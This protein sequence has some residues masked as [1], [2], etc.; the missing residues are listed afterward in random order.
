VAPKLSHSN[1]GDSWIGNV[2]SLKRVDNH[3]VFEGALA[4]ARYSASVV[5]CATTL[6]FLDVYEMGLI[7]KK[8]MYVDVDVRS[9]TFPTQ[10]T[11]E[12]VFKTEGPAL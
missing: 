12:Y 2:S 10:S 9:S 7:P 5:D 4:S 8:L 1:R 3:I 11:S 6:C